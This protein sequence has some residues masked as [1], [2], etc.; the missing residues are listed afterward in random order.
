MV[1]QVNEEKLKFFQQFCRGREKVGRD[2]ARLDGGGEGEL[3]ATSSRHRRAKAE[4]VQREN[5]I[6]SAARQR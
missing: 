2:V 6:I 1:L 5:E 3:P 4:R